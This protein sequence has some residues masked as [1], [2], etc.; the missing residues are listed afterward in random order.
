MPIAL[1]VGGGSGH[2]PA[3]LG[4]PDPGAVSLALCARVV[5][6]QLAE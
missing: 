2:D 6:A 1:L 5:A 4:H 3:F